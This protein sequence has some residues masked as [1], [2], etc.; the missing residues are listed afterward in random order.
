[1]TLGTPTL[2]EMSCLEVGEQGVVIPNEARDADAEASRAW[3]RHVETHATPDHSIIGDCF[4]TVETMG[5][6]RCKMVVRT[7]IGAER[8]GSKNGT[9][10]AEVLRDPVRRPCGRNPVSRCQEVHEFD[11]MGHPENVAS[12]LLRKEANESYDRGGPLIHPHGPTSWSESPLRAVQQSYCNPCAIPSV[13]QWSRPT[14]YQLGVIQ[15]A[16][17]AQN[18]PSE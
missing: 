8:H 7:S 15:R 1:M 18:G 16:F 13:Y 2:I 5:W 6:G 10:R 14:M 11:K 17:Y 3:G 4:G 12:F 9:C